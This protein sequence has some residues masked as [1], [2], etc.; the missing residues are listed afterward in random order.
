MAELAGG[1][2]VAVEDDDEAGL[3]VL[4]KVTIAT[5]DDEDEEDARA[6]GEM[7][8]LATTAEGEVAADVAATIVD[9]E[10]GLEDDPLRRS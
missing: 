1:G 8:E 5:D 4:V 7:T 2:L 9:V 10:T 3:V 6:D